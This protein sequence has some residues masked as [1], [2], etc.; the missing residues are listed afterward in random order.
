MYQC[1]ELRNFDQAKQHHNTHHQEYCVSVTDCLK[2]RLAWSDLQLIHDVV[3]VLATQESHNSIEAVSR[4]GIRF[5]N[6]L[7][8]AGVVEPFLRSL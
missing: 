6:P 1:Q 5:K 4:L 2:S 7:E 8:S 3:L